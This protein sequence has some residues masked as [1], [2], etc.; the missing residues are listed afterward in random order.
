MTRNMRLLMLCSGIWAASVLLSPA[1]KGA[2]PDSSDGEVLIE[3]DSA[4]YEG[5]PL[6][7]KRVITVE[8][9]GDSYRADVYAP[10]LTRRGA[11][12]LTPA[13]VEEITQIKREMSQLRGELERIR[14]ASASLGERYGALVRTAYG[15]IPSTGDI[16]GKEGRVRLDKREEE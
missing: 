12:F 14:K 16:T 15:V 10:V 1:V 4:G 13:Q 5:T 2:T 11:L 9:G 8:R 6:T 3:G 7:V